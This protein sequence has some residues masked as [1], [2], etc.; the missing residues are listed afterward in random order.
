MNKLYLGIDIGSVMIKGVIIDKNENI[1]TSAWTDVNG[2]QIMA[3]RKLLKMLKNDLDLDNYQIVSVGVTGVSR[4]LVGTFLE[5]KTIKNEILALAIGTSSLY[6]DVK[7][8][9]DIGGE[10]AKMILLDDGVVTDYVMNSACMAGVGI[11]LDNIVKRF[12][13]DYVNLKVDSEIDITAKCMLQ[14]ES[15]INHK[16]ALGYSK[17]EVFRGVCKMIVKNYLSDA[18]GKNI[19]SPVVFTGGVSR[20]PIIYEYLKKDTGKKIIVDKNANLMGALGIAIM[21]MKSKYERKFNFDIL[22]D[23]LTTKMTKCPNCEHN[24]KLVMVYRNNEIINYWG[25]KCQ[26]PVKQHN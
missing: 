1:M 3:T 22:N 25:N 14:A 19:K 26:K 11:Y 15:D 8:I 21:A 2:D 7:T 6:P 23:T 10:D 24:C 13:I 9:V 20:Y 18:K 5:A 16:L 12:K 4:K 17:E